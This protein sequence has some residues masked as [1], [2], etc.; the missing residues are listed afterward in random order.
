MTEIKT[1]TDYKCYPLGDAAIVIEF[2]SIIDPT[3]NFR[4][5]SVCNWLDEYT[6]EGFVE[7][8]P[9]YTTITIYYQPFIVGYDELLEM[10]IE[11]LAEE[12]SDAEQERVLIEI[13]VLYGGKYGVDLHSVAKHN[14][15]TIEE[16]VAIHSGAEY[17]V[18]MI[19]FAP[20]FPYMGGLDERIAAP[21]K[22]SPSAKIL[23]GSVGIAGMQTG[24]YP[25]ETPGGWQI[26]GRTPLKL[27][28]V[29]R[30]NPSL[31][32]AG[33][34]VRFKAISEEQYFYMEGDD[35]GY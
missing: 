7:Y 21:R 12:S 16:V 9:A 14:R 1:S 13:P 34:L 5:R 2:G 20:G 10:V 3:I 24:I 31:L 4:I 35:Y 15:L 19:G 32:K 33:N 22:T 30:D 29:E 8:V 11:M 23:S 18:Y 17:L 6:F 26:I 28:D 25:M 27:F